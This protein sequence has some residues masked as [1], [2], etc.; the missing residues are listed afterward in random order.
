VATLAG[1]VQASATPIS[2]IRG[3][4]LLMNVICATIP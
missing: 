3:K 2:K 1:K 4:A